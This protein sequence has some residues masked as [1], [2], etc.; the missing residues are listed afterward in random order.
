MYKVFILKKKGAY[1]NLKILT[2]IKL[3]LMMK[4]CLYYDALILSQNVTPKVT[5]LL[6]FIVVG[7]LFSHALFNLNSTSLIVTHYKWL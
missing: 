7:V 5:F 1:L 2:K 4:Y 6:S 3:N